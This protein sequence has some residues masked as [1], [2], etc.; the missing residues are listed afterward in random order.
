MYDVI[1]IGG[2]PAG[3][4]AALILGRALRKVIV[5]D[6]GKPRNYRSRHAHGFI[7]RD[8]VNPLELLRIGRDELTKYDVAFANK[9]IVNASCL[10]D[11]F[12]VKDEEGAAY[13]SKKLLIATGLV[14]DLPSIEGVEKFYGSSVFH[15][16][17]CDGWEMRLKPLAAYGKG[18]SGA[19]L[20]MALKNW[21]DDVVLLTD[22]KKLTDKEIEGLELQGIPYRTEKVVRLEGESGVLQ[23][24]FFDD[25]SYI[26]RNGM[27]FTSEQYQRSSLASEL[28]CSFTPKGVVQTGRYQQTNVK[29]LYVAGDAAR[30]MQLVVIAAAEGAKA[31]V[32]INTELQ[33]EEQKLKPIDK[34]IR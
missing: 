17:Y 5:F 6:S 12:E 3:L 21:S 8:G 31:A 10:G 14:D 16:P 18:K 11:S 9:T 2:G 15:C 13:C 33:K 26:E 22:G 24:I 19:G 30:D 27:F 23:R 34:I 20:A 25:G 4:N 32:V 29:G 1:I 28:G 7:S